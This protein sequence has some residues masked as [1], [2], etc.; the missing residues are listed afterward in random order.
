[1]GKTDLPCRGI[2]GQA[3]VLQSAYKLAEC[4]KSI[5]NNETHDHALT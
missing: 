1:M 5:L 3:D 2:F 4:H